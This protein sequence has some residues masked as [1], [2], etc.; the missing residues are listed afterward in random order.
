MDANRDHDPVELARK[1]REI[2]YEVWTSEPR[3]VT[4]I[5]ETLDAVCETYDNPEIAAHLDWTRAIGHMVDGRLDDCLASLESSDRRFLALNLNHAAATTRISRLYAL[6]MLGRYDEAIA[7]GISA[8]DVFLAENDLFSLAKVEHNIGNL[9]VRRD[10]YADAERHYRAAHAVFVQLGDDSQAAM[11]EN[12]LGFTFAAQNRFRDA[13]AIYASGLRRAERH[14]LTAIRADI[15]ASISTLYLYQG[16]YDAALAFLERAR[17]KYEQLDMPTQTAGVVLELADIYLELNLLPEACAFYEQTEA[18]FASLGMRADLA[19]AKRNHARAL[20]LGGE[21]VAAAVLFEE[22]REIFIGE[23]NVIAA[24]TVSLFRAND[25]VADGRFDDAERK[26][27]MASAV[28]RDGGSVRLELIAERL[29]GEVAEARG[30]KTKAIAILQSVLERAADRSRQIEYLALVALGRL[31]GNENYLHRAIEISE[32]LG[33]A[34]A[35]EEFRTAFMADKSRP[36]DE[37]A[38]LALERDDAAGAFTIHDRGRSRSLLESIGAGPDAGDDLEALRTD[39][40]WHYSRLSRRSG[41]IAGPT[42][43]LAALRRNAETLE[44]ELAEKLRRAAV[45]S[46]H[47][48]AGIGELD[49]AALGRHL[50]DAVFIEFAYFKGVLNAFVLDR[51]KLVVVRDLG[52]QRE[53]AA[54]T[55]RFMFQMMTARAY[56]GLSD[57]GKS[58]AFERLLRHARGLYDKLLR[59]LEEHTRG[60]RLII[61]PTSCLHQIPFAALHDGEHFVVETNE[62][63]VVPGG[64]VLLNCFENGRRDPKTAV[65]AGIADDSAPLVGREAELVAGLFESSVSLVGDDATLSAFRASCGAADVVHIACH[66]SF[67]VDNP[68]FSSLAFA[69]GR[70]TAIDAAGLDLAGRFVALSAC[71]SGRGRVVGGEESIG[72]ARAMFAAGASSVLMSRWK[73]DDAA[74]LSLMTGFYKR[75]TAGTD[76]ATALRESQIELLESRPHPYFWAP[77]ALAGRG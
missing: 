68:G 44:K 62:T 58:A 75:F 33:G 36:Y 64:A 50:G 45:R 34:L 27:A 24:A 26:L 29:R 61:A 39:L 19:R 2:C 14:D 3:R 70:L 15:E 59:P 30:E 8:R 46:V 57:A 32:T 6:A 60:R 74:G 35:A 49:V 77:F 17:Q 69:D 10:R 28:F 11:L 5:V 1:L 63:I 18:R 38:R 67:R 47:A 43:D 21:R 22:A 76:A 41:A 51:E 4:S 25:L 37:L 55:E 65:V 72:L 71:E 56:S 53:I 20:S 9:F 48:A 13:E 66:G 23:E 40:N 31:L 12:N 52:A 16:R 73:V 54:E 42:E 7:C